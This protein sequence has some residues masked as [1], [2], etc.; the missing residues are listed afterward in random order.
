M[1]F[2]AQTVALS[3]LALI[4]TAATLTGRVI[5]ISDGDTITMLLDR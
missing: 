1:R 3:L 2:A 4:A 5:G